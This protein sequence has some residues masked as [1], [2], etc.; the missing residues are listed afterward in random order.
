V[1]NRGA[2]RGER[3]TAVC[4]QTSDAVLEVV[5]SLTPHILGA[6][7]TIEEPFLLQ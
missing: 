2:A 7:D 6:T 4:C 3:L 1:P 5:E